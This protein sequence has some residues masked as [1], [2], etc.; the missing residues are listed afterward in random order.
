MFVPPKGDEPVVFSEM[1]KGVE[2]SRYRGKDVYDA[3]RGRPG[4]AGLKRKSSLR[5]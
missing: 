5:D 4:T 1:L 2:W 3:A